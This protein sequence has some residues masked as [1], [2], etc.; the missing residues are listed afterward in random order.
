LVFV[1]R[2]Q[3]EIDD[4]MRGDLLRGFWRK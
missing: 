1:A 4:D 3:K 2:L